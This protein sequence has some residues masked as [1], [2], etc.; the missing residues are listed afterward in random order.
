MDVELRGFQ[1]EST[2]FSPN[3]F[4]K[5]IKSHGR[6]LAILASYLDAGADFSFPQLMVWL[7]P[8]TTRNID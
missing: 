3:L 1:S 2:T 4:T 5:Y 6:Y 8:D 7:L